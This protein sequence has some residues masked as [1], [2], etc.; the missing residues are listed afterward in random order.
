[1]RI[2]HITHIDI[3]VDEEDNEATAIFYYYDIEVMIDPLYNV[4]EDTLQ[5][6]VRELKEAYQVPVSIIYL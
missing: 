4:D 6:Y 1:M 3:D 2:T 5:L